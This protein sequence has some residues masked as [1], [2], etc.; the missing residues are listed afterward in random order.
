M[1]FIHSLLLTLLCNSSLSLASLYFLSDNVVGPDFYQYFDWEAI[2]D[3]THGRVL[4]SPRLALSLSLE[5]TEELAFR[6]YVNQATSIKEN[7]T[8]A[9]QDT[10]ILRTDFL[11]VLTPDG[12]GRNS[13]R[14][15]SKKTFTTHV[16]M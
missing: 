14:I 10:F 13:V 15:K 8:F 1:K 3:P 9:C 11:T 12:P 16:A 5:I 4:V 2:P 7:L 6:N